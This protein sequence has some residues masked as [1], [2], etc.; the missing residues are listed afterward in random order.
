MKK[1]PSQSPESKPAAEPWILVVDDEVMVRQLIETVL[2]DR[3][4]SVQQTDGADGVMKLL[5]AAATPP[6]VMICDVLMPKTDGLELTRRMLAKY[7]TLDVILISGHLADAAWFPA[8][9]GKIRLL[10]KPF[11]N[12]D[13]VAA[14]KEA[15][16]N[17]SHLT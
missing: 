3:G 15:L 14:V 2:L 10:R 6:S 1:T 8:D 11:L 7:P 16:F 12:E 5:A 4:W 17:Q 9:L 13:L